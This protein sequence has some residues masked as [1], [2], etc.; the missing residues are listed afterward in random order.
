MELTNPRELRALLERHGFR[1]SKGLGQNFL[2]DASVPR[3]I[4]EGSGAAQEHWVLEIGPGAGCLTVQ[5]ASRAGRVTA[6][7]KDAR[8]APVLAETIGDFDNVNVVTADFLKLDL[9]ELA[10]EYSG[11]LAPVVCANLPY[12][13]TGPAIA[14]LLE[15]RI[16]Q[17]LTI[18]IQREVGQRLCASPGTSEYGAFTVF[19]GWYAQVETLFDVSPSC[20]MP[21]PK[22]TSRVIR[23]NTRNDP[24]QDVPSEEQFFKVVRSAFA[25]RRKTLLNALAAGFGDIPKKDIAA[26]IAQAGL[27]EKVRGEELGIPEFAH[28]TRCLYR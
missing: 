7:E 9:A 6:V 4:A 24:P 14:K 28:L 10:G 26:A 27:P 22:V 19:V 5:L 20:F 2:I 11:G 1:F 3:R 25:Q 18:M 8:L 15:S 23:L 12:N 16:F 13:I 17:S 21:P